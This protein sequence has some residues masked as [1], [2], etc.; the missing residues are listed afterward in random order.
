MKR[1]ST[2]NTERLI[3]MNERSEF[4]LPIWNLHFDGWVKGGKMKKLTVCS[5]NT[6]L[7][8]CVGRRAAQGRV[9]TSS[10]TRPYRDWFTRLPTV[11]PLA[12]NYW[13]RFVA[14][15]DSTRY[16]AQPYVA[17]YSASEPTITMRFTNL[18]NLYLT[19]LLSRQV[20]KC[21]AWRSTQV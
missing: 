2:T 18:I 13:S 20:N 6:W 11:N 1:E 15:L 3:E 8:P 14:P 7:R 21:F 19:I 12:A 16:A 5:G 10:H 17:E 4:N 9:T